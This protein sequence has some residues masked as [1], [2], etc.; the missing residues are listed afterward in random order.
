MRSEPIRP[1]RLVLVQLFMA[2]FTT[3]GSAHVQFKP[4]DA[5]Q[6]LLRGL[7]LW[8]DLLDVANG[9]FVDRVA[10]AVIL[11]ARDMVNDMPVPNAKGRVVHVLVGLLNLIDRNNDDLHDLFRT[12]REA[13]FDLQSRRMGRPSAD[14]VLQLRTF[15]LP[16]P[17]DQLR[18]Q[19]LVEQLPDINR[20][21]H[22]LVDRSR[23]FADE[24][25]SVLA[26]KSAVLPVQARE[27]GRASR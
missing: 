21:Y 16:L 6:L 8:R 13:L 25:R 17:G 1:T 26:H 10:D 12:T 11:L 5:F 20:A 14:L 22:D 4:V 27:E 9:L 23:R 24:L 15:A 2:L 7:Y 18:I 19:A 3:P